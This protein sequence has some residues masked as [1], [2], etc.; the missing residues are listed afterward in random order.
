MPLLFPDA[1]GIPLPFRLRSLG[2]GH[3]QEPIRRPF[4]YPYHHWLQ[5]KAGVFQ[6]GIGDATEW[7]RVGDGVYLAPDEPHEYRSGG[8]DDLI[9]D[10]LAF[11]GPGIHEVLQ[12]GPLK[13]SGV[14]RLATPGLV[15]GVLERAWHVASSP[16]ST[17][18]MATGLRLSASV[19]ELLVALAEEAA[20]TGELSTSSRLGRLEP[21][22]SALLQQPAH[23][24]TVGEMAALLGQTPQSLGRLFRKAL[25]RSPLEYLVGLRLNRALQLLAERPNLRV[26][27]VGTAVGY[28]DTSYFVRLFHQ[29]EGLTPGQFQQLH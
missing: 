5:V 27:E 21:V 15:T 14:Y 20:A 6:L 19:Y 3:L 16:S 9:V 11:D 18:A 8:A 1:P 23:P 12:S 4:G 25:G 28:S 24:W 29:R 2:V 17:G 22:L 26:H 13:R 10:F 7:A